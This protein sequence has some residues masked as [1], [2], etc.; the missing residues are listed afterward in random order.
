[1]SGVAS[2]VRRLPALI[3]NSDSFSGQHLVFMLIGWHASNMSSG[4]ERNELL[5]SE[6]HA[7]PT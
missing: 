5:A 7:L 1:M 6:V 3:E 2:K 4:E